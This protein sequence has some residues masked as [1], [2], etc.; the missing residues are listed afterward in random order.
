MSNLSKLLK[1][2]TWFTSK[3]QKI[4]RHN[5]R[6]AIAGTRK[7]KRE[8]D[9]L[10]APR[11]RLR[12]EEGSIH[13][14]G[15]NPHVIITGSRWLSP[16][17]KEWNSSGIYNW[18]MKTGPVQEGTNSSVAHATTIADFDAQ[19]QLHNN[20]TADPA[21]RH[22][23][24]IEGPESPHTNGRGAEYSARPLT[25]M[26]PPARPLKKLP[27][28]R[29]SA[30]L[31][32]YDE[33]DA[34]EDAENEADNRDAASVAPSTISKRGLP[35]PD[36][37]DLEQARRHAAAVRLPHDSGIWALS[38]KQLFYHLSLRGFEPLIPEN[39]MIDFQTLPLSLFA[40]DNTDPPLIKVLNGTEFRAQRAL[41]DLIETGKVVRDK[42][43]A[44]PSANPAKTIEKHVKD[45]FT[46]ALSDGSFDTLHDKYIPTYH[47]MTRRR[48]QTTADAIASL[49][50]KLRKLATRHRDRLGILSSIESG[51]A[52]SA[53]SEL[54]NKTTQLY[55]D[56]AVP[57]PP[58]LVGILIVAKFL[59]IFTLNGYNS[60]AASETED[61]N[62]SR[63]RFIAKFD[64]GDP[65]YD[66][67]NAIAIAI[68]V[69]HIREGME[70]KGFEKLVG[71]KTEDG[72]AASP[73]MN[74]SPGR[75]V[76][77]KGKRKSTSKGKGKQAVNSG[78]FNGEVDEHG[79]DEAVVIDS[80]PDR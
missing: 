3:Q 11:K 61:I 51:T 58:V 70:M 17:A 14:S 52:A 46:W 2:W 76:A 22:A 7:R 67:W 69:V 77:A 44:G 33:M 8:D 56:S 34:A 5:A 36:E 6:K 16:Q 43:F 32:E 15:T 12:D 26:P 10:E 4:D 64:F 49:N 18:L 31:V 29:R 40:N 27:K 30:H 73:G 71:I 57:E 47:I 72:E 13:D 55:D 19:A 25:S 42:S 75:M 24:I 53:L 38:E 37:F 74:V 66:V 68:T 35:Q 41:R 23:V 59:V 20:A 60:L 78:W 65:A 54:H 50:S 80:D 63:L 21:S 79:E 28:T 39:W 62:D 1:P 48:G 45:Y 9:P